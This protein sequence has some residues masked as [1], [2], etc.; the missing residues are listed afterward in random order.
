MKA[1]D[2]RWERK[3]LLKWTLHYKEQ[4]ISVFMFFLNSIFLISIYMHYS[5][6]GKIMKLKKQYAAV[7]LL[8]LTGAEKDWAVFHSL[9]A[10]SSWI[11]DLFCFN[12]FFAYPKVEGLLKTAKDQASYLKT[13]H[14]TWMDETW[15]LKKQ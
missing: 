15:V 2:K 5:F 1:R 9:L 13:I 7:E 8:L 3:D 10:F 11:F 12:F 6:L 4:R 14:L